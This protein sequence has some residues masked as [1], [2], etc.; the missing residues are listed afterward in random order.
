MEC[1]YRVPP[2]VTR[3]LR[4]FEVMIMDVMMETISSVS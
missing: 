4:F 3:S 1:S 2:F